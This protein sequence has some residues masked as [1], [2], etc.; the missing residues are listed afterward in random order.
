[1]EVFKSKIDKWVMICSV[2][3][4]FACVLGASVSIKVGGTVNYV[5]AGIILI[6]GMGF[7]L[8][9]LVSTRYIVNDVDLKIISGP[10]SWNIPIQSIISIQQTNSTVTSPALSFDRLEI[11]YDQ[12]K[13]IIISPNDKE[14]FIQKLSNDKP[15]VIGKKTQKQIIGKVTKNNTK[16][17]KRNVKST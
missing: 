4:A 17:N 2:L 1:M 10:F 5:F 9:I 12:D 11:I 13:S 7:P 8:W 14:K 16:K 6:I 15:I 3:S